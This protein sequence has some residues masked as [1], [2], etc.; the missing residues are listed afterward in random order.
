MKSAATELPTPSRSASSLRVALVCNTAWAIYTYR[1]G[2]L[3]ALADAGAEIVVIA[4]RDRTFEPLAAMG[5]RCIDLPV[6]SKGTNPLDDLRTLAALYR[7]YRA[8]RPDVV[9][10]YTIKPNIYGSVAAWLARVPSVAVTTGLGYVFIQSSRAA[11]VAK[12]LYR[13]AFRFPREVWFLNR[14]DLDAFTA[15]RLLAHPDRARLLHGEGVDVDQ[16]PYTPP[17][18]RETF[19]FVLI[20][21]LLWDK[22]VAEYVDAARQLRAHYPH[23]RFRLLGPTGVDNPSAITRDEVAAWER[24]GVIEYAGETADVRPYIADADCVVLPSYR[25]GVPRTLMEA[26]AMGRPVVATDVPG[27]REVVADR[28]NGLLCE[29]RNAAS[30]A[31]ALKKMLDMDAGARRAMGERGRKKIEKEFDERAVVQRYRELVRQLTGATF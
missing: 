15:E 7:H 6:A 21:R 8:V 25:E 11:Q 16:F 1:Q 19:V 27:C 9:F 26:G 28:D 3:R 30:L 20:G 10:H 31:A 17:P 5:C 12:R 13:F 2:L 4:P 14:D 18:A 24:E 29:A 22:G 23:A